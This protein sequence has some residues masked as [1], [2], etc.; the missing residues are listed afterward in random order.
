MR[1]GFSGVG[2]KKNIKIF[3]KKKLSVF[4]ENKLLN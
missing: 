1:G 4:A 2:F 3:D